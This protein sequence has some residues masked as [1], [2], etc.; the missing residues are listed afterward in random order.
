MHLRH[1]VTSCTI[2]TEPSAAPVNE[3]HNCQPLIVEPT[4]YDAWLDPTTPANISQEGGLQ[5]PPSWLVW[6]F[7]SRPSSW[8]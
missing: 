4:Y 7:V 2:I 8:P 5:D 3:I 1:C 6:S